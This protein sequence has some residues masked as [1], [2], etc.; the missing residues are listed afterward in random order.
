[1]NLGVFGTLGDE[2]ETLERIEIL[3]QFHA[4][5][6]TAV[7]ISDGARSIRWMT[8]LCPFESFVGAEIVPIGRVRHPFSIAEVA[9]D[10]AGSD[11]RPDTRRQRES[12]PRSGPEDKRA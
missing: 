11:H 2:D 7:C 3:G 12:R 9:F 5:Q 4:R 1:M 6:Y 8:A 10:D